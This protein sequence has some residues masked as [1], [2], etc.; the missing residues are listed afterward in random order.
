LNPRADLAAAHLS[1]QEG[2]VLS[3]V[4][5]RMS[6][7][8]ICLISG[9]GEPATVA[10][11][12]KLKAALIIITSAPMSELPPEVAPPSA[13][14]KFAAPAARAAATSPVGRGRAGT[15]PAGTPPGATPATGTPV[16][17]RPVPLLPVAELDAAVFADGGELSEPARRRILSFHQQLPQLDLFARLEVDTSAD[18]Q[19]IRRAYF[20]LSKEFHPDRYYGKDV[21]RFKDL[22]SDLF[23]AISAAFATLSNDD[24]RAVYLALLQDADRPEP[25]PAGGHPGRFVAAD[26]I[27]DHEP[28][29]RRRGRDDER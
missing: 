28:P 8:E 15:P 13:N 26:T 17:A 21:G 19:E 18:R 22:L 16:A 24:E 20:R 2:F 11:L 25:A 7:G 3:R 4:D 5:G 27:P 23:K 29:P 10:I 14:R 12:Q 6:L 1:P 9:L